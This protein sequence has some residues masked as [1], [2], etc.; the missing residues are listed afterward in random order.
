MIRISHV[1][2]ADFW[3]TP[4]SHHYSAASRR[5][6]VLRLKKAAGAVVVATKLTLVL[7]RP[8]EILRLALQGLLVFRLC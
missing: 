5:E 2:Q 6:R 8:T 1:L 3:A 7:A 4:G